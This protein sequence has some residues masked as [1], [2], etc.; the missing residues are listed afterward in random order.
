MSEWRTAVVVGASSG[1]GA[2]LARKLAIG[3]TR[4]ALLARRQD[5]LD[6]VRSSIA[7]AGAGDRAIAIAH[8]VTDYDAVPELFDRIE[9]ELGPVDLVVYAAGIMTEVAADEYTFEKDRRMVEVNLLGAMAWLDQA[10][11][12][13]EA[14]RSGTLIGISSIAGDRGRRGN[15][16][17]AT[18]KAGLTTFLEALRNRLTCEGVRVVTIRP[19]FVATQMTQGMDGLFWLVSADEAAD[20]ILA[21]ARRGPVDVHVPRRWWLVSFIVRA[22]PSWIFRWL[23]I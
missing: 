10:A 12:R 23:P 19:G 17:Y 20:M 1:I 6:D 16:A 18:S 3:G 11:A 21:A 5:A 8:D 15:P 14:R 4:V 22:I 9:D 2:A 7:T 13:M